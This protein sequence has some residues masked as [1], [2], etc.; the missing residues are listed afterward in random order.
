MNRQPKALLPKA[1]MPSA[2]AS[3]PYSGCGQLISS[4]GS[5]DRPPGLG[6]IWPSMIA[7]ASWG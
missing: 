1:R 3:L 7:S 5:Q 6:P 4:P 2:M